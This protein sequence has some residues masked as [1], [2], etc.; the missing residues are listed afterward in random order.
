MPWAEATDYTA[1]LVFGPTISQEAPHANAGGYNRVKRRYQI[2]RE[3]WNLPRSATERSFIEQMLQPE[4]PANLNELRLQLQDVE[5]GAQIIRPFSY[6]CVLK[7]N[8]A[9]SGDIGLSNYTRRP[10]LDMVKTVEPAVLNSGFFKTSEIKKEGFQYVL[11]TSKE[12]PPTVR[13]AWLA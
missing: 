8:A 10:V 13:L 1:R 12:L 7:M 3:Y 11:K 9:I 5:Y 6:S 4:L 2:L